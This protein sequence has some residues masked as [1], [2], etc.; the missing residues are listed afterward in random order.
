[1]ASSNSIL[2]INRLLSL[3]EQSPFLLVEDSLSQSSA[4]FTQE[5]VSRVPTTPIVYLSFETVNAPSF[6]A[7]FVQCLGLSVE[8]IHSKIESNASRKTIVMVDSLNYIPPSQITKF[9]KM[10]VHPNVILYGVYHNSIPHIETQDYP[11]SLQLLQF[12]ATSIFEIRPRLKNMDEEEVEHQ[13]DIWRFPIGEI[14]SSEF[15]VTLTNRR[16]SGRSVV[17]KYEIN[18][19]THEITP[20]VSKA[21]EDAV[22]DEELLK[23]LTTFNLTTSTRQKHARQE[24]ELPF[25]MA[26]NG[27]GAV[28]GAIVYQYEQDDDYDEE[29]PYEDPF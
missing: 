23:N 5:F 10:L 15:Y 22:G 3:K 11:S 18:S 26:Q 6:A 17:H 14:N 13:M 16:K 7:N 19:D 4:Y 28:G 1:M 20:Y 29:D 21:K 12:M 2:L 9:I 27:E 25:M 8:E 24:V